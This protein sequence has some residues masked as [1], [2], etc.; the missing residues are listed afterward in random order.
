MEYLDFQGSFA[1]I[2][3]EEIVNSFRKTYGRERVQG[4]I[5]SFERHGDMRRGRFETEDVVK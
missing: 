2:P 1:D 3:V 5:E 4:W